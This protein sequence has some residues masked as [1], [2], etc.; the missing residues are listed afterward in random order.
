MIATWFP[1]W[2]VNKLT[3]TAIGHASDPAIDRDHEPSCAPDVRL[4]V[5]MLRHEYTDYDMDQSAERHAEACAAIAA[6]YPWLADECVGQKARRMAEE[7][8]SA[9]HVA[10]QVAVAA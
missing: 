1:D 4:V 2:T 5:N 7:A 9:L 10:E 8:E 3:K 6:T